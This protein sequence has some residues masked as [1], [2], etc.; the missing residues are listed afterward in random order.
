MASAF[1]LLE[2]VSEPILPLRQQWFTASKGGYATVSSPIQPELW[3]KA[4]KDVSLILSYRDLPVFLIHGPIL[5]TD[6]A[7]WDPFASKMSLAES[8]TGILKGSRC[9]IWKSVPRG[10]FVWY[11]TFWINREMDGAVVR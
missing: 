7:R 1:N 6:L 5:S 11:E 8:G 9:V 4:K 2:T 3:I 10:R